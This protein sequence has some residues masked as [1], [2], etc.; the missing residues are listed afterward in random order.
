MGKVISV[1]FNF[2]YGICNYH[3]EIEGKRKKYSLNPDH[4]FS[5][6]PVN[7]EIQALC[8]LLWTDERK[9]SWAERQRYSKMTP[10]ERKEAGY[11]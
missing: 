4:N 5:D 6:S 9:S 7:S 8:E 3:E 11:N 1:S 2:Q 10:E